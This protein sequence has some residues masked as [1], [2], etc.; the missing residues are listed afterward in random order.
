MVTNE[1]PKT[2]DLL[3]YLPLFSIL[4]LIFGF[5]HLQGY[6]QHFNINILNHLNTGELLFSLLPFSF[7]LLVFWVLLWPFA[8][9]PIEKIL[10]K[11]QVKSDSL[12]NFIALIVIALISTF[13]FVYISGVFSK[14][15]VSTWNTGIYT[16][17]MFLLIMMG[18]LATST[19]SVTN[20]K[21]GFFFLIVIW[22]SVT[23]FLVGSQNAKVIKELG[24]KS[25]YTIKVGSEVIMSDTSQFVIGETQSSIFFYNK[26]T[27]STRV[28]KRDEIDSLVIK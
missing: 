14:S 4:G 24:N 17:V 6:Y 21:Q 16:T 28:I 10:E 9:F 11:V 5:L 20:L 7:F 22:I 27:L 15:Y 18:F 1:S 19:I 3:R 26:S 8:I 2:N 23:L 13:F 25:K 12:M